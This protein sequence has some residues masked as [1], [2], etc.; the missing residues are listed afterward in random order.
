MPYAAPACCKVDSTLDVNERTVYYF[1]LSEVEEIEFLVRD[2]SKEIGTP[3]CS[4]FAFACPIFLFSCPAR[5]PD[6]NIFFLSIFVTTETAAH[7][8]RYL[9]TTNA[10]LRLRLRLGWVGLGWVGLGWVDGLGWWVGLGCGFWDCCKCPPAW[11]PRESYLSQSRLNRLL[12][13]RSEWYP[14]NRQVRAG[15]L[16]PGMHDGRLAKRFYWNRA[17]T[18]RMLFCPFTRSSPQMHGTIQ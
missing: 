17:K 5:P 3:C 11:V 6:P 1:K 16:A 7:Q 18:S 4:S 8:Y 13:F 14:S 12:Y 15:E 2:G 9:C 10:G